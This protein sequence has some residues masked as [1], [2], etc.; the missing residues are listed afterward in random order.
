MV[1]KSKA[2][3]SAA[4]ILILET[5]RKSLPLSELESPHLQKG[6]DNNSTRSTGS[7]QELSETIQGSLAHSRLC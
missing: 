1:V 7:L 2:L 3:E 5:L 6:N 4:G